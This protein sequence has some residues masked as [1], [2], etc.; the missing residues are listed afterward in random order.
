MALWD[1]GYEIDKDVLAYTVGNDP[2]VDLTLVPYD[3]AAS[4]AHAKM[5]EKIGVLTSDELRQLLE[6]L[7][8][9]T[10][11]WNKG[12]FVIE[13]EDE[14]CHTAIE[15]AL[16]AKYGDLGKK[17]HTA[18]SRNDQVL[19]ALRLYEKETL[20]DMRTRLEAFAQALPVGDETPMPGYTHMQPA[21]PTTVGTWLGSFRAATEDDVRLLEAVL[22]MIDQNP[23]GSGA[24]FG[25]PFFEIDRQLTAQELGF[26]R[27]QE[28]PIYV[29]LSR[30]KFEV[31]VLS[32]LSQVAFDMN[33][34][35]TD[36]ILFSMKELGFVSLPE[37][38]CTGSSVMPQKKNPDALELARANYHVVVGYELTVKSL[39]ANLIS[40]YNRDMQL[41]KEPLFKAAEV[42]KQ[43][44]TIMTH[45]V[46]A[47]SVN[48][49][50]CA[51]AMTDELYAT[52]EAY[53]LVQLGAPFRD[54]Y[55]K[56][57]ESFRSRK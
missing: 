31:A 40:G 54:A 57:A 11:L 10:A 24:G 48:A 47:M 8:E 19:V 12:E 38:F 25:I 46:E 55:R 15:K 16:T 27:V 29:Q 51:E 34:L 39:I 17:I 53:K 30:G 56:V 14:D 18:R 21:M 26:A 1:K 32:V 43:T 42:T 20:A 45:V 37:S 28:N 52:E 50:R 7:D 9:I 2:E 36:I 13:P 22:D 23:L 44:V 3:C 5:L 49:E 6:G 35:A 33:K 4:A 41:M